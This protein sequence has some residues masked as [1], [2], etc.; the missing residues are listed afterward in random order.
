[1]EILNKYK[2]RL[3]CPAIGKVKQVEEAVEELIS[4]AH[5]KEEWPGGVVETKESIFLLANVL[6]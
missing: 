3:T 1:M 6:V 4:H 2:R 5:E